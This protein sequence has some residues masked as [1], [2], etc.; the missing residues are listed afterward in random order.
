M[1]YKIVTSMLLMLMAGCAQ[2]PEL[3]Q[4]EPRKPDS[5]VVLMQNNDG[6]TGQ[7]IVSDNFA[8]STTVDHAGLAVELNDPAAGAHEL[9]KD[10]L[11]NDFKEATS[12][13]PP[14]PV[15]FLLYF[16]TGGTALTPESEALV[17]QVLREVENRQA[18]DVSI[19]GHT[20]TVGKAEVNEALALK[21]AQAIADMIEQAG[22]KTKD[23]TVTSHGE[24]NLLIKTADEVAEE[25]NRR[26]EITV[27]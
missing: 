22:L 11:A 13:R 21:R 15:S 19:I 10:K 26:V 14:L 1:R 3:A 24:R 5:Y 20:D 8:N 18:P 4:P 2:Q 27:R 17:P 6:S 16:K 7:I 9:D 23:I 25:R 12:I